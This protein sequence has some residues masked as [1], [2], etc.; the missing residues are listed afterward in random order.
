MPNAAPGA[1]IETA[2]LTVKVQGKDAAQ[3]KDRFDAVV[4]H[5]KQG[6]RSTPRA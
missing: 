6:G 5:L 4:D 1:T 2:N 3:R